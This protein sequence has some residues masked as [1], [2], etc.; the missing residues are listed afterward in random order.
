MHSLNISITTSIPK[1][2]VY[3]IFRAL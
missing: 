3:T 1:E 2:I